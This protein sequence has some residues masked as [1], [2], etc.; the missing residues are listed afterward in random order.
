MVSSHGYVPDSEAA[1]G[2]DRGACLLG[3]P[4]RRQL[5]IRREVLSSNECMK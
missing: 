4:F 3:E 2:L 5:H 1:N